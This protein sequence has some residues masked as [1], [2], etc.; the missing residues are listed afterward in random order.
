MYF[1]LLKHNVIKLQ[2]YDDEL[3]WCKNKATRILTTNLGYEGILKK[4]IRR[5]EFGSGV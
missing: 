1:F 4:K 5:K 2:D 3:K